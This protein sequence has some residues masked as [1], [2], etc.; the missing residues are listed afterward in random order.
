MTPPPRKNNDDDRR[1]Q[2]LWNYLLTV[3][4]SAATGAGLTWL[5]SSQRSEQ[6]FHSNAI[7]PSSS[8]NAL[9]PDVSG[10]SPG[11]AAVV[12][13]NFAYDHQHWS[14][15]IR[16]YQEAIACGVNIAD[17]RTDLGNALRFSG[18][19]DQA[20]DQYTT[21]QTLDPQHENSLFNQ[22]SLSASAVRPYDTCGLRKARQ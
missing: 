8:S 6:G 21:A 20:L 16:K 10:L 4:V 12:A 14:E 2:S 3:L 18:Q 5:I 13:G 7:V 22:I 11:E 19:P 9:T 17:V 1:S 15:A